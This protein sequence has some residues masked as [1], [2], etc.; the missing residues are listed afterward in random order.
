[1]AGVIHYL[2]MPKAEIKC[3]IDITQEQESSTISGIVSCPECLVP[4][5]CVNCG[6]ETTWDHHYNSFMCKGGDCLVDGFAIIYELD[7]TPRDILV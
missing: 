3:G 7:G 1:M 5:V 4:P 2:E 6:E